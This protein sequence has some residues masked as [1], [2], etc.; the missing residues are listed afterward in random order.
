MPIKEILNRSYKLAYDEHV[1]ELLSIPEKYLEEVRPNKQV[2]YTELLDAYNSD[3]AR[4]LN[5]FGLTLE[6]E[7][8]K[9]LESKGSITVHE[10]GDVQATIEDYLKPELY[11][12]RFEILLESIDRTLSRYG[13]H[14]DAERHRVDIPKS[15]AEVHAKNTCRRIKEKVFNEID[16]FMLKSQTPTGGVGFYKRLNHLYNNHQFVFWG[17]GLVISIILG[18][19]FV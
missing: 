19:L 17:A 13:L 18:A 2:R 1:A 5:E 7:T 8:M 15:L 4:S 16:V 12:K 10:K 3:V 11:L 9:V 6:A 14:F